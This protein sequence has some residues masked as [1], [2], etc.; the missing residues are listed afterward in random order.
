MIADHLDEAIEDLTE[1]TQYADLFVT[2]VREAEPVNEE[3]RK[4]LTEFEDKT[5]AKFHKNLHARE[6]LYAYQMLRRF[7]PYL[8]KMIIAIAEDLPASYFEKT[9]VYIIIGRVV[10]FDN[11]PPLVINQ[12]MSNF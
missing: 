3:V 11:G 9:S 8:K 12:I 5:I 7:E 10:V 2:M 4:S 6:K 1:A